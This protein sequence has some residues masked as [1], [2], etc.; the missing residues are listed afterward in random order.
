MLAYMT[1]VIQNYVDLP[2]RP[3]H[4]GLTMCMDSCDDMISMTGVLRYI[5]HNTHL[6]VKL[7][8]RLGPFMTSSA[9]KNAMASFVVWRVIENR[10]P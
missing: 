9:S 8:P 10:P 1:R 4:N 2:N 3:R 6:K 5:S 7:V